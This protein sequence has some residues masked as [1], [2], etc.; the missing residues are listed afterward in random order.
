L[1]LACNPGNNLPSKSQTIKNVG[2]YLVP[3]FSFGVMTSCDSDL[4]FLQGSGPLWPRNGWVSALSNCYTLV[5]WMLCV[6]DAFLRSAINPPTT[7]DSTFAGYL[8]AVKALGSN[9]PNVGR[10][11]VPQGLR[12][13]TIPWTIFRLPIPAQ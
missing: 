2:R 5:F 6:D 1:I 10:S 11:L 12:V 13:L 3:S 4:V 8:A 9:A 7:G